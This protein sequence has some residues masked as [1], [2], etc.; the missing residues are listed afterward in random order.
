[1]KILLAISKAID[2]LTERVGGIMAVIVILTIII[3]FAN[4][5]LRKLS[6]AIG[7]TLITNQLIQAQWYLFSLLFLLG[8]PYIL[9]HNVNVRVD[10]CMPSGGRANV[11]S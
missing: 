4:A 3:G 5:F 11:R 10:F 2:W 7:Q 6:G 8:F 9:K 1:M